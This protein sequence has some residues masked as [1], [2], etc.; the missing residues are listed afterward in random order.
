[1]RI[2]A[3]IWKNSFC[4]SKRK[5]SEPSWDPVTILSFTSNLTTASARFYISIRCIW[6]TSA[7]D[8]RRSRKGRRLETSSAGRKTGSVPAGTS[9]KILLTILPLISA[10]Q[11]GRKPKITLYSNTKKIKSRKVRIRF[12]CGCAKQKPTR[13]GFLLFLDPQKSFFQIFHK[14][15]HLL[16]SSTTYKIFT[17]RDRHKLKGRLFHSTENKTL[18]TATQHFINKTYG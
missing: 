8:R 5:K 9:K 10:P 15:F 11:Q 2:R 13:P 1:M 18:S 7:N 6:D 16:M 4:G 14:D 17:I 12:S 3:R